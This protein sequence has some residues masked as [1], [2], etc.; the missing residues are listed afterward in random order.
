M[1]SYKAW[2][3]PKVLFPP[4]P[5]SRNATFCNTC[6]R[7][8]LYIYHSIYNSMSKRDIN[9]LHIGLAHCRVCFKVKLL[10]PMA[11]GNTCSV[12]R[13]AAG[14]AMEPQLH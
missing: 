8:I 9:V 7:T 14:T 6:T 2:L 13:G 10:F 5:V 4:K 11:M 1:K 12:V 3:L